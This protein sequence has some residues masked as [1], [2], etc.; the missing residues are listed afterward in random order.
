M[1]S[2]EAET[3]DFNETC[4]AIGAVECWLGSIEK[5][6]FKSL[7]LITKNAMEE[8]PEDG[9]ERDEW[10]FHCAAQ[11]VLVIDQIQWTAG[12]EEA[13]Y[14]IMQGKNKAAL[15]ELLQFSDEQLQA[16]INLVRGDLGK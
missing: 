4:Y 13:V 3:V 16:M 6:M 10:L 2:P 5:A 7:Y 12:I 9:R 14:Q 11:C 8:Y 15:K 1:V